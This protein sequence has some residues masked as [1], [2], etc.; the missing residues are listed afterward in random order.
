MKPSLIEEGDVGAKPSRFF[1]LP[2]TCIA[3]SV[4]WLFVALDGA[5]FGHLAA[6]PARL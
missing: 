5:A 6:P 2:A 4:R 1:L 3:S